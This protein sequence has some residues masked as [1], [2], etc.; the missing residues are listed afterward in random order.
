MG[1]DIDRKRKRGHNRK[2]KRSAPKSSDPYLL[3][4]VK[5]Y[6]FL[7]RRT[8]SIFNR[9]ILDRLC[10]SRTNKSPISVAQIA[11]HM[12]NQKQDSIAVIV[13][14]VLD[15]PR[16][17]DLPKLRVCALKFSSSARSRIVNAG[18][19]AL[20]FDQLALKAPT[21]KGTVLLRG[22]RKS[23]VK[24]KYFGKVG[25]PGSHVRPRVIGKSR[26]EERARGRRAS[27]GYSK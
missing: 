17:L 13:A 20:T 23:A 16:L 11:D 12:K 15:D 5:L 18:G 9:K 8:S 22:P 14:P 21:G 6:R 4:L 3:L 2:S 1:I 7:S 26:K 27:R 24:Y 19:E 25:V 10:H